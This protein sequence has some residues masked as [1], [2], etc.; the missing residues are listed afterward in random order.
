MLPARIM[1][2]GSVIR[3]DPIPVREFIE[4]NATFHLDMHF[5]QLM[6]LRA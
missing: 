3:D 6:A 5:A 4:G 1:H 2:A